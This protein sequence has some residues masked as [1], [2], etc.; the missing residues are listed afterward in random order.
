MQAGGGS[1]RQEITYERGRGCGRTVF[2]HVEADGCDGKP[3]REEHGFWSHRLGFRSRL[4]HF[5]AGVV[6]ASYL[7]SLCPDSPAV[8]WE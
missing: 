7:T 8:P 2:S 6:L 5:L 1:M 4:H 3:K